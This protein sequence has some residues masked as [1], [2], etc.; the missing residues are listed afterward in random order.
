[1]F[2][3]STSPLQIAVCLALLICCGC[4]GGPS[5]VVPP[6]I[7]ADDAGE[8][9]VAQY[10]Q[11]GD[12]LLS[13]TEL[14]SCPGILNRIDR[15][16]ADQDEHVSADE[17]AQRIEMWQA[18]KM[19]LMPLGVKVTLNGKPLASAELKFIPESFLGDAV[20]PAT[21]TTD[22]YGT[23]TPAIAAEEL[24]ADLADIQGMHLGLYQ[25]QITH[26]KKKLPATPVGIEID[27]TDQWNGIRIDLKSKIGLADLIIH[28]VIATKSCYSLSVGRTVFDFEV[29]KPLRLSI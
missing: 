6:G 11:D 19:A 17:I 5:R 10:D 4:S 3:T 18:T 14:T 13:K 24:P 8:Q 22:R 7:D 16:D 23:A 2:R 9:A 28:A 26:P 29:A 12:G 1:M 15:Y 25:V 27:H 20:K 21:G